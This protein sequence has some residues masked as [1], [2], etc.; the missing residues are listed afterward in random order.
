MTFT[1]KNQITVIEDV[2]FCKWWLQAQKYENVKQIREW[3]HQWLAFSFRI[4]VFH[5]TGIY[6]TVWL[7]MVGTF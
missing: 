3:M 6:K 7:W 2:L 1:G 5:L 4:G